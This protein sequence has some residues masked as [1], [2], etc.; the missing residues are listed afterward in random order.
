VNVSP[1]KL[2]PVHACAFQYPD[3]QLAVEPVLAQNLRVSVAWGL[4]G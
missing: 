3:V 1:L 4:S 2:D